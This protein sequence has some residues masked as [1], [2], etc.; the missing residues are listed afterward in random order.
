MRFERYPKI[1]RLGDEENEGILLGK[2]VFIQEKIDGANASIWLNDEGV[3]TCGSRN[4]DLTNCASGFN[5]LLE[6]VKNHVGINQL[7]MDNPTFRL[8]GEW[9]VKHTVQYNETAYK[10][11]YL[12]DIK[13]DGKFLSS[14]E[15]NKIAEDYGIEKPHTFACMEYPEI[16]KIEELVGISKL[17]NKGE[18]VVIKNADYVNAFGETPYAKI[19]TQNFKEDNAIVF[20]GNN[21]FS[22]TYHEMRIVNKYITLARVKKN[23]Q[24]IETITDKKLTINDTSR[25]INTV[26]HDMLTEEI[27]NI[28]KD[29]VMINFKK[30]S[31]LSQK[32]AARIFHDILNGFESVAYSSDLRK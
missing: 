15:V 29:T 4:Q 9:L 24:K 18:G 16:A 25:V 12:F 17:G 22:E 7:L 10:H 19:V 11:F 8:F 6:Y 23:I 3:V 13:N 31:G 30:L 28:Q 21:K 5:G 26:Y 20:G 1:K 2:R 32:K 27:W 14:D